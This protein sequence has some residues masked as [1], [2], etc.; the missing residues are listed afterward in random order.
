MDTGDRVL[1]VDGHS[2][3]FSWPDTRLLHQRSALAAR[4]ELV[5]RLTRYQDCSGARVVVVFDGAGPRLQAGDSPAEG[6]Q[7]LFAPAGSTADDVIERLA[8]AY[9]ERLDFTV[10]TRDLAEA[11]AVMAA[12]GHVISPVTLREWLERAEESFQAGLARR[13]RKQ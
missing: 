12:G 10:A 1:V 11:H 2:V 3:L 9:A 7:I 5:R 8:R 4:A 6:P 13:R